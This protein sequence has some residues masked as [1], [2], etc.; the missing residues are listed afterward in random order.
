MNPPPPWWR[1]D[2]TH[3]RRTMI[4]MLL[5]RTIGI[6][7]VV[8]TS[9]G[10]ASFAG[11]RERYVVCSYDQ[12]WDSALDAVKSRSVKVHD[13]DKGFIQTNWL[14]IPAPGRTFGIMRR[15]IADS[16]DRSRI[17]L[18]LERM[19]D[20]TRLSFVEE[21]ERYAFRGGSRM[22]GWAPTDPSEEVMGD[23]QSRLDV[24]LKEHGCPAT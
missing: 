13:K 2:G 12:V 9:A 19:S 24:K 14:E 6:L 22:F 1:V 20:V 5:A 10:C 21:R 16:R 23:V 15:E 17:V 7:L 8:S 3:M 11:V 18:T 4:P